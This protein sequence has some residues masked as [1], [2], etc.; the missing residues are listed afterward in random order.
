[1]L[2]LLDTPHWST[3]QGRFELPDT[4][5]GWLVGF[6]ALQRDG[7]GRERLCALLWPDAAAAQAQHNLRANLYRVRVLLT[8]WG[9]ASALQADRHRVRLALDSDVA[10]LRRHLAN[11][12]D[13]AALSTYRRPLLSTVGL[14]A[15]P[16]LHE[17]AEL[18]RAALHGQWRAAAL[19]HLAA[20]T[21]PPERA[22]VWCETLAE[23]DPLDEEAL[24]H[25][26]RALASLGRQREAAQLAAAFRA[27]HEHDFGVASAP[28]AAPAAPA[29]EPAPRDAF[30]GREVELQQ[31]DAMLAAGRIVTIVGPGG[32]GKSRLARELARRCGARWRDSAVGVAL[33][34][35][36]QAASLV[37]RLA[38]ACGLAPPLDDARRLEAALASRAH[39]V[40]L[41]NA[42]HLAAEL[43][44]LLER[45]QRLAPDVGWL[46]TS[47]APLGLAPERVFALDGLARPDAGEEL[48]N[49]DAALGFEALRLFDLR[50]R[51][52]CPDF[53]LAACLAPALELV[54]ATGGWPLAIELAASA[55]A[56]HD[57][58][59]LLGE[60]RQSLDAL[61]FG[62]APGRA[63]RDTVRASLEWSW[64][65]LSPDERTALAALSVTRGGFTRAAA[66]AVAGC[67]AALLARLL[68]R[69]LVQAVGAGRLDLHP[70]MAQFAA[71]RLADGATEQA[72]ARQRHA[73]HFAELLQTCA[74]ASADR[75]APLLQQIETDFENCRAA[76]L[77]LV[78][79]GAAPPLANAAR[80]WSEYGTARGRAREL[81]PLVAGALALVGADDAARAALLQ[82][83]AIL[84]Y[85]GGEL[86]TALALA[87]EALAADG[88]NDAGRRAMLNT[89]ALVL[90]DLGRYDEAERCAHEGLASARTAGI[91]REIASQANTCAILA[92]TRGDH[93]AAAALYAEAI[94]IHRRTANQRG[95]ATCLNNLGNVQRARGD[96]AAAQRCFEESLRASEQHGIPSSRAFALANLALVH[97]RLG[98]AALALSFADRARAEPA[99]EVAVRLGAHSATLLARL[100]QGDFDQAAAALAAMV[101]EARQTGH[102]AALLEALAC[103]ARLQ[104]A[105]GERSGALALFSWL[106]THPRLPA[107]QRD[108]CR[109]AFDTLVPTAAERQQAQDTARGF[110]L[111]LLLE[112]ALR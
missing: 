9:A 21:L 51:A 94:A 84:H 70:L 73:N 16:A 13:A 64:R 83:S 102:D 87:R 31:L 23:A 41:D 78:E 80:A 85:R 110:E 99:A 18:E 106:L 22:L 12:C 19:G 67:D 15:F 92:K 79:R 30:V 36:P 82:A 24:A 6:L 93:A 40:V 105:R 54:R 112:M 98:H 57:L 10:L 32:V 34:G 53:D 17:W 60:L 74:A 14:A 3:P 65:L 88:S 76:W 25:R 35:L 89:A 81:A 7:V 86:D 47:R 28:V 2:H 43:A 52:A 62:A 90:K 50:A 42:E 111:E 4:L 91:E 95:L 100:D 45:W 61:E 1:M 101:K 97:Q 33:A 5:P 68:Q 27:R 75:M 20:G 108:D 55:L 44:P 39:L 59:A 49:A 71:E 26:L 37:A 48:A 8:A 96:L 11:G 58:P 56:H 104:A 107:M 38:H 77:E 29:R 109:A 69:S 63:Q 103:H 46:L 66:L 72:V